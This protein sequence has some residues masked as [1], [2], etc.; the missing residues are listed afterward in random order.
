MTKL[1][2]NL[3]K[4]KLQEKVDRL[5]VLVD[6]AIKYHADNRDMLIYDLKCAK[7]QLLDLTK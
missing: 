6:A 7:N 1:Q 5:Q 3:S 2:E 4:S